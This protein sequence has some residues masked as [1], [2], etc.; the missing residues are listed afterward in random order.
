MSKIS[1]TA[2][3]MLRYIDVQSL[4]IVQPPAT[5]PHSFISHIQPLLAI[6]GLEHVLLNFNHHTF[7]F[8]DEDLRLLTASWPSI[9]YLGIGFKC[10][11][12]S[13]PLVTTLSYV[14][15][16]CRQ[17]RYLTIPAWCRPLDEREPCD[18]TA[19]VMHPLQELRTNTM[20]W[21]AMRG[22]DIAVALTQAF[23]YLVWYDQYVST[24]ALDALSNR[25]THGVAILAEKTKKRYCL[26][27][28][29]FVCTQLHIPT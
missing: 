21:H 19:P 2:V 16:I 8:T 28:S 17:L 25:L 7:R 12:E 3:H 23:P 20:Q 4:A 5:G 13:L 27:P 18:I 9:Q 29:C 24:L 1:P 6:H 15:N 22:H 10:D 11:L 26:T 14:T